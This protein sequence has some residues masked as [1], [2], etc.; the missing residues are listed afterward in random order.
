MPTDDNMSTMITNLNNN[1][2]LLSKKKGK[3]V[4]ECEE[5]SS[6]A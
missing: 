1:L 5:G 4:S 6:D 2:P 3:K